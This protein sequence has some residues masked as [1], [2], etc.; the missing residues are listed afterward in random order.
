MNNFKIKLDILYFLVSSGE[1]RNLKEIQEYLEEKIGETVN[2]RTIKKYLSDMKRDLDIDFVNKQGRYGGYKISKS[3]RDFFLR[4]SLDVFEPREKEAIYSAF[5]IASKNPEFSSR[6]KNMEIIFKYGKDFDFSHLDYEYK[7][8]KHWHRN[9]NYYTNLYRIREALIKARVIFIN[10]KYQER[11]NDILHKKVTP[12]F[13][14]RWANETLMICKNNDRKIKTISLNNIEDVEILSEKAIR[15]NTPEEQDYK[16]HL[17]S[18]KT[19][20]KADHTFYIV[21]EILD[22]EGLKFYALNYHEHTEEWEE[23]GRIRISFNS[24]Q[25]AAQFL[26]IMKKH[27]KIIDISP[28]IN[29]FIKEEIVPTINS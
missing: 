9:S 15:L 1:H 24:I 28:E 22:E 13:L 20:L 4:N 29:N 2:V 3:S 7:I 10:T 18:V 5:S 19:N 6:E 21:M 27:I 17:N 26:I 8:E 12:L 23:Q 25:R 11:D 14:I 16:Y